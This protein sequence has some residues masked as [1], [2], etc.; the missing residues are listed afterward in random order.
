VNN[1]EQAQIALERRNQTAPLRAR[2]RQYG[3]T[4]VAETGEFD[5]IWN[6]ILLREVQ[7]EEVD[8]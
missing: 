1:R 5:P 7:S 4:L 6:R 2:L 3:E 8:Q